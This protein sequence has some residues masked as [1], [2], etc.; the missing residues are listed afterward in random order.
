MAPLNTS[1]LNETFDL[2]THP[3]RR[4]VLYHL[5]TK[6]RDVGIETLAAAIAD[7]NEAH[8]RME[9]ASHIDKIKT[10]LYHTH[11]PKLADAG[12]ITVD[13]TMDS[14]GLA[15]TDGLDRFLADAARIDGYGHIAAD[16]TLT[17]A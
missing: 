6:V 13:T 8:S 17:R 14:I 3:H 12:F 10:A 11:L 9:R 15:R 1:R 16:G 7:W 2:L 4:Y 5:R